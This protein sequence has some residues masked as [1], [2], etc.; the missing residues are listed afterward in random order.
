[1]CPRSLISQFNPRLRPLPGHFKSLEVTVIV[2]E[3]RK[4]LHG[5][6]ANQPRLVPTA[7]PSEADFKLY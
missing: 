4:L 7:R 5:A 3:D 6:T 2:E 1:M